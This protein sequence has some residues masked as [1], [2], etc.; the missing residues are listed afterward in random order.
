V[1]TIDAQKEETLKMFF[2][3]FFLLECRKKIILTGLV[4]KN[5]DKN[6]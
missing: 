3:K 1:W 2:S 4:E 5:P 6:Y